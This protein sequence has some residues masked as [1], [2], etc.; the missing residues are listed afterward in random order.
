MFRKQERAGSPDSWCFRLFYAVIFL[1][2]PVS[3]KSLFHVS[4]YLYLPD[5]ENR[6][7]VKTIN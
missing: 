3:E 2:R 1:E 6:I 7:F 4:K 5:P